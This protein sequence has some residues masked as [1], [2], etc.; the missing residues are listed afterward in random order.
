VPVST[1][2]T[3]KPAQPPL[4]LAAGVLTSAGAAGPLSWG[5][6]GSGGGLGSVLAFTAAA[7]SADANPPGFVAA[8]GSAGTGRLEIT[9]TA[10]SVFPTLIAGADGQTLI[11]SVVAGAFTLTLGPTGGGLLAPFR[12]ANPNILNLLDAVTLYYYGGAVNQWVRA[13]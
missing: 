11:V 3:F 7:G 8:A 10:N 12:Q 9:L 1:P 2:P 5:P 6:S 13:R 4:Q